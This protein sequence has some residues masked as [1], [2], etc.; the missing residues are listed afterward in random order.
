M[1]KSIIVPPGSAPPL[2]PY[3]PGTRAGNTVYVS[4]TLAIGPN[5]E[6][7]GVGDVTAQTRHVLEAVKGVVEAAGGTMAD[8]AFNTIILKD[9]ADYAAMNAVWAATVQPSRRGR[10]ATGVKS[11]G[12]GD[13]GEGG[14]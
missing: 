4:G 3:S 8:I 10:V 9:L 13:S 6:S 11:Y 7:V 5:G 1:P 12:P 14:T 2:A